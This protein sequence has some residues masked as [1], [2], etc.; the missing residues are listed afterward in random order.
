M[1]IFVQFLF[2]TYLCIQESDTMLI[3]L[4]CPVLVEGVREGGRVGGQ[5]CSVTSS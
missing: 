3:F 5:R 1:K 4:P 2:A